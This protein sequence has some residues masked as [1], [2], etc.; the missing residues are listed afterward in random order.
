MSYKGVSQ[1]SQIVF[2]EGKVERLEDEVSRMIRR[3]RHAE[4]EAM[5]LRG[6][7][8]DKLYKELLYL[9]DLLKR[10]ST[11]SWPPRDIELE[12]EEALK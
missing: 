1:G 3:A 4:D 12:I 8:D 5:R 9:K 11:I 6:L 7:T 10:I 2:L